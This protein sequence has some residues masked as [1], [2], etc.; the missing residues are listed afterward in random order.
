M[1]QKAPAFILPSDKQEPK[2]KTS[3][4]APEFKFSSDPEVVSIPKDIGVGAVSG[5]QRG[6][7][8]LPETV[9]GLADIISAVPGMAV[10]GG[11][12]GA[13]KLGIVPEGSADKYTATMENI[14]KEAEERQKK[15]GR[16]TSLPTT[17]EVQEA[18]KFVGIPIAPR[19]KTP[20][21]RITETATEFVPSGL[22]GPGTML[23]KGLISA[24]AGLTGG[25]GK[26]SFRGTPY[27]DVATFV[28]S[29]PGAIAGKSG[30]SVLE[31]RAPAAVARRAEDIAARV[32]Q[33]AIPEPAKTAAKLESLTG[34][35]RP[36][37]VP[38]VVPTTS[39]LA[40]EESMAGLEGELRDIGGRGTTARLVQE[41]INKE[42]QQAGA[43]TL[44]Q[45]LDRKVPQSFDLQSVYQL[46]DNPQGNAAL[47]VNSM[48]SALERQ[49]DVAA[50]NAWKNPALKGAGLFKERVVSPLV[51]YIN[52]L[53][54]VAREAFP[55]NLRSQLDAIVNEPGPA[56]SRIDFQTLQDLRSMALRTARN[57]FNSPNP[58]NAPD[59]YGFAE[60]IADVMSDQG[61]VWLNNQ[62]AIDAWKAA[63]AATKEYKDIFDKGFLADLVEEKAKGVPKISPEATLQKMLGG[64]NAAQNVRQLRD[65]FGN[66]ADQDIA[67]FMVGK[68]TKNGEK[69]VTIADV[70]KFATDPKNASIINEIPNL[71]ARLQNIAQRAGESAVQ[72][73][74]RQFADKVETVVRGGSPRALSD[75]ISNNKDKFARLFPDKQTQEFV[76]QLKNSADIVQ[77]VKPGRPVS[78]E[79]LDKL[80]ENQILS[81]LYGRAVGAVSDAT[82]GALGGAIAAKMVGLTGPAAP[83]I[84]AIALSTRSPQGA[85]SAITSSVNRFFFKN[86][87]EAAQEILQDAM[88][89]PELMAALLKKPTPENITALDVLLSGAKR[90]PFIAEQVARPGYMQQ[91]REDRAGRKSGGR[92]TSNAAEALLRDLKRRKVMMANK[93]EQMLS[94]PDD[95]VVQA[96]EAAKR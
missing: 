59:V 8:S 93:T 2:P 87:K 49:K 24:G 52:N 25:I 70:Q 61:N 5:T 9:Q 85:S 53:N 3:P 43:Q 60:K 20:L 62:V 38:G 57:A 18:S 40:R 4:S 64:D 45:I 90:A 21:G 11:I 92:T 33:E 41:Q 14:R 67:D 15:Y 77:T 69:L 51:D 65:V 95:A 68:M 74:A 83:A 42:A 46:A 6:V 35:G 44:N 22:L 23:E 30:A 7:Y 16:A 37:Y 86:T 63:R 39:Q 1:D 78:T 81:I 31:S 66:A 55:S 56:G 27:E 12:Y 96:L 32:A 29:L 54:P 36:S 94:L 50:S 88:T 58:V 91:I 89:N 79:T 26:E 72:A 48:V 82:I 10:K 28:S 47:N 34:A 80:S 19:P 71:R 13:E 84:G 75:F 17:A 76:D 73:E